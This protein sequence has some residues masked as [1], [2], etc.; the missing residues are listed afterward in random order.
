M[1]EGAQHFAAQEVGLDRLFERG[2]GAELDLH[3]GRRIG[4]RAGVYEDRQ[5]RALGV[6]QGQGLDTVAARHLQ[7][8]QGYVDGG[9]AHDVE[10]LQSVTGLND[11]E[12]EAAEQVGDASADLQVVV[13]EED[14][15]D[16]MHGEAGPAWG[17]EARHEQSPCR[18][19]S[20]SVSR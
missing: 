18:L 5:A 10:R 11:L 16:G 12:T 17:P 13:G 19:N 8:E 2:K 15:A 7:V 3:G 14:A 20:P 1:V 4:E 6:D 9:S